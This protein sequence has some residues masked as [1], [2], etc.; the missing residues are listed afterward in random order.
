MHKGK[1]QRA[2][3]F[4][5]PLGGFAEGE[6]EAAEFRI[7]HYCKAQRQPLHPP[8]GRSPI[9]QMLGRSWRHALLCFAFLKAF[10]A[11]TAML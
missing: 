4:K 9:S 7:C 10:P 3:P 1:E 11:S 6:D 2:G 8:A 5:L